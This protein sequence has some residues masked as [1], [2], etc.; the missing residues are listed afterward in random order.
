MDRKDKVEGEGSYSGTR[1]YNERT[2]RFIKSGRVATA[3]RKAAPKSKDE[4]VIA[5]PPM[6]GCHSKVNVTSPPP[7]SWKA[8]RWEAGRRSPLSANGT[9]TDAV[10]PHVSGRDKRTCQYG[11]YAGQVTDGEFVPL[12]PDRVPHPFIIGQPLDP[13][14]DRHRGVHVD[15]LPRIRVPDHHRS[16]R[17]PIGVP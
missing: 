12:Q 2:R 17:R 16:R 6:Y 5:Q 14:G 15:S 9:V 11:V 1:D 7:V 10:V 4:N 3:A 13:I 8:G